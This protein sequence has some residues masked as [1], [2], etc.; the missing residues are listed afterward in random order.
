MKRFLAVLAL[1]QLVTAAWWLAEDHRCDPLQK[2]W[3]PYT[4]WRFFRSFD[5]TFGFRAMATGGFPISSRHFIRMTHCNMGKVDYEAGVPCLRKD[6][7][8][9]NTDYCV[10][11]TTCFRPVR[12]KKYATRDMA[13]YLPFA[14]FVGGLF[15]CPNFRATGVNCTNDN[16]VPVKP[17]VADFSGLKW[18]EYPTYTSI[19]QQVPYLYTPDV[20]DVRFRWPFGNSDWAEFLDVDEHYDWSEDDRSAVNKAV[21]ESVN[22]L[23]VYLDASDEVLVEAMSWGHWSKVF[24]QVEETARSFVSKTM[25]AMADKISVDEPRVR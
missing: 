13:V 2:G 16:A 7:F 1:V 18:T 10:S 24:G 11:P 14:S 17:L 25:R 3:L 4:G 23:H 19:E 6:D 15:M 8:V 22:W 9:W 12:R 5:Y 20:L 21:T